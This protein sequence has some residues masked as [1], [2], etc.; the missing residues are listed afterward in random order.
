M[1]SYS[2]YVVDDEELIR[3]ASLLTLGKAYQVDVFAD[4]ESCIAA[5]RS[6]PADLVLLDIGLPGMSGIDTLKAIKTACPDVLVIMITANDDIDM[7]ISAMKLGA[8]DYVVKPIN[9]DALEVNIRNALATI[10]LRKEVQLLQKK[11]LQENLPYFIGESD[12]IQEVMHLVRM[13]AK[14]PDA[15]VLILGETGTGKELIASAVHYYSP[16][17]KGP[18]VPVNCSTIPDNLIESELFGYEKGA[19]SGADPAGKKG[20]IEAAAGGTLFLDEVGDLSSQAQAK[21]LRFLENGEYY[22]VGGTH[23]RRA[24]TRVVAATNKELEPLMEKNLFRQDL[25][26]RL[27]TIKVEVPSLNRRPQD[28]VPMAQHFLSEFGRKY[29]KAFT[30]IGREAEQALRAHQWKGNIRELRNMI[31]RAVLL[32]GGPELTPPELGLNSGPA[33]G[34]GGGATDAG[35]L[36]SA[37]SPQGLDLP[38]LHESLD[39]HYFRKA[40]ELN[41]GNA[42]M[43]A[44]QLN[45]SYYAFRRRREKLKI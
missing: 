20:L 22:K 30:G 16:H 5:M 11:Y 31:E 4:G 39:R 41:D 19:F 25:F 9:M 17:F 21:L 38:A 35:N 7:V 24:A 40:L 32:G 18:F 1:I 45:M 6:N 12:T 23:L 43:A 36:F 44:H 10:K 27:A 28:I 42:T 8:Y 29:G 14:S 34:E 33:A 2:I 3:E 26:F 37:L 13:V 15:T